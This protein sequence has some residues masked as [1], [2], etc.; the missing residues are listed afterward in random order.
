MKNEKYSNYSFFNFNLINFNCSIITR[1]IRSIVYFNYYTG[2]KKEV[3]KTVITN[4]YQY[5]YFLPFIFAK[6]NP[7]ITAEG[8]PF[9]SYCFSMF[10]LS[11]AVLICFF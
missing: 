5:S 9:I 2:T 11:L 6:F 3:T 7:N 10:I 4:K 8:D 1:L